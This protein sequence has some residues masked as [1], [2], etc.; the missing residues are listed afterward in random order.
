MKKIIRIFDG[1]LACCLSI[2]Y[3]FVAFGSAALPND[4]NVYD[5]SVVKYN[6]IYSVTAKEDQISQVGYQTADAV[7]DNQV[8]LKLFNS[9]PVKTV[10]MSKKSKEKVIV[11]GEA[12]GIKIHTNGV[13]VVGTKNINIDGK[14]CNPAK[15]AGIE[16]GDIIISINGQDVHSSTDV[17]K[18][19]T[20]NNGKEYRVRVK[21]GERYKTFSL[22]PVY[23]QADACYKVGL[24]VRDSTAGIG[25]ITFYNPANSSVAALGHPITDVDTNEIMPI[26]KGEAVRAKVTK[27]Y[28]SS[29]GST[30]SICCDFLTSSIG[31]LTENTS[32]GIYGTYDCQIKNANLYEVASA[33]EVEKGQCQILTTVT[34][35]GPKFYS[36]EIIRISYRE[37]NEQKNMVIKITDDELL[38]ITGG[39]VQGMSG[40]PIIQNGRLIGALTHVMVDEPKKGYAIF[41]ES[42]LQI[43]NEVE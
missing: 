16:T 5:N 20:D 35:D 14:D 12:F 28:K 19:L 39:I 3:I 24:W 8:E 27:I 29:S 17:E 6:S 26:L 36:A 18:I 25:T 42:M 10:S 23:S 37:N 32:S 2:I 41:A 31:T 21:R 30:G 34:E 11:S 13:M 38:K 7:N 9:I 22:V 40:S 4:V 15:E 33:T 1:V 43:S